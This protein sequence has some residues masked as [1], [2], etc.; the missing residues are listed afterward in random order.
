MKTHPYMGHFDLS[1]R[2]GRAGRF[3]H[4]YVETPH[5]S[6]FVTYICSFRWDRMAAP[7]ESIRRILRAGRAYR[8]RSSSQR[9]FA[10]GFGAKRPRNFRHT[11]KEGLR[12][13]SR[14]FGRA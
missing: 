4:I 1:L 2:P 8:S 3:S 12:A 5:D 10:T 6:G 7:G 13:L 14:P 11:V 9:F